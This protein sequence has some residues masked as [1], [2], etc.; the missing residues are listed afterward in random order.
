MD[1]E[2]PAD[3]AA[4]EAPPPPQE[5]EPR[6]RPWLAAL[7]AW[8]LPGAGHVYTGRWAR[9]LAFCALV[10]LLVFMGVSLD[11][12]LWRPEGVPLADGSAT[13]AALFTALS[14]GLGGPYAGLLAA[15]YRGQVS[16]AGYEYGTVFLLTAALMNLLLIFDALDVARG[17]K[18]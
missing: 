7:L 12:R 4:A 1:R 3:A 15:G 9:G 18:P 10:L 2:P 13:L 5:L 16:A 8:L 14:A 6:G 17:H 11:G